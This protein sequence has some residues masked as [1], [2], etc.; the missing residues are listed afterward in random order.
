MVRTIASL[1]NRLWLVVFT[2]IRREA[3]FTVDH[4]AKLPIRDD[5]FTLSFHDPPPSIRHILN[6]DLHDPAYYRN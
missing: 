5:G 3:N 6:R 1:V 2:F 4:L